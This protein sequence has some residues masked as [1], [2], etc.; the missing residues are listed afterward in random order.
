MSP[1]PQLP[2]ITS[3]ATPVL[4]LSTTPQSPAAAPVRRTAAP[5]KRATLRGKK[6][7]SEA[8][9]AAQVVIKKAAA[10][11]VAGKKSSPQKA[12]GQKPLSQTLAPAKAKKTVSPL[13]IKKDKLV[14]DSFTIPKAEYAVLAELKQRAV[15]LALSV[16]K[17]ELLR[18]GVKM[19]ATLS[20]VALLTALAQVPAVKTGRP[21]FKK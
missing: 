10:K 21:P 13:K 9:P 7:A 6:V 4:P 8:S 2:D 16:K 12:A 5:V 18:A 3:A 17:S 1:T 15:R 11:K 20:D 19:L 14:R